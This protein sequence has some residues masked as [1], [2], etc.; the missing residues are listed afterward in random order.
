MDSSSAALRTDVLQAE[1]D[2]PTVVHENVCVQ[3][4]VTILPSVTSG[5]SRSHCLG[6][7][8]I[9]VC[10]GRLEQSC[11]F[12]VSQNICVQIPLVFSATATAVPNG[13]VCGAQGTGECPAGLACTYT[14]GY[15][16][17]HSDETN[18]LITANGGSVMLGSGGGL[19][20]VVTTANA[21]NVLHFNTPS[22]P[23]PDEPPYAGAYQNLYAQLLAAKLNVFRLIALGVQP[24]NAAL[25]AIIAAD[26]FLASSP[27]G[28]MDGASDVQE[29]L[30]QFN[31]GKTL[32]CPSHCGE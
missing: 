5:E 8:I 16:R 24:C 7:P 2:C 28:G 18:A 11:T 6:G 20:F 3:G 15:F 14:I 12:T 30:A 19:S 10:P 25:V 31:E 9:G 27:E 4:L 22:P 32:G 26:N 23:A 21:N 13:L 17:N 29:P 1:D